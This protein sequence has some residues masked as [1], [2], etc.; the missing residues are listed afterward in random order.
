MAVPC[1]YC[2][3]E[4]SR[5][6]FAHENSKSGHVFCNRTCAVTYN[7][8]HKTTGIR[9][10][11][12][13]MWLEAQLRVLYPDLTLLACDKTTINSELDLYFPDLKLAFELNGIL[14]YEPIYGPE[15]LAQI[16]N[17]DH[18]KF[19]ACIENSISLCIIDSSHMKHFKESK[20]ASFLALM[21]NIIDQKL[22][23]IARLERTTP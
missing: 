7:N 19:A 18:R 16:Q 14:H 20:A 11:K 21:T 9:R 17:N 12:L 23:E 2:G 15:K 3:A 13:E 10:S 1:G 6:R 5:V 8:T 22:S 4:V